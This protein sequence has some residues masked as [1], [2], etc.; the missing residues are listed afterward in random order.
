MK[1]MPRP[2]RIAADVS[3]DAARARLPA[4]ARGHALQHLDG[5]RIGEPAQPE[6]HGIGLGHRGDLVHERLH[7]EGVGDLARRADGR[8]AERRVG[9]QWT[10]AFRL[11]MA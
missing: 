4:H 11:G 9:I 2:V 7:R 10:T 1:A 8:G 3:G 5:A 6:L